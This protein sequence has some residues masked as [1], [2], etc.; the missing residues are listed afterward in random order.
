MQPTPMGPYHA[1][2]DGLH[3]AHVGST[4]R[5]SNGVGAVLGRTLVLHQLDHAGARA[6]VT[7]IPVDPS[8]SEPGRQ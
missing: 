7:G 2:L 4:Q 1:K 8:L 3:V 5:E 6:R